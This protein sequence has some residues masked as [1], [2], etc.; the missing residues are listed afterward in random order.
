MTLSGNLGFVPLDEVLRLLTRS[1]NVGVVEITNGDRS[2]RIFVAE[3]GV[4]MATTFDDHELRARLV[5]SGYL[6]ADASEQSVPFNENL[7]SLVREMTVESI[8]QMNTEESDFQVVRDVSS[9][10]SAPQPFDL[11][12]VLEDSVKR[13]AEWEKVSQL[14]PDLTAQMKINREL[15]AETVE[16]NRESWRLL[17]EIG[18]GSSVRDLATS[19]GTTEFAVARVA[20]SMV[21]SDLLVIEGGYRE[22]GQHDYSEPHDYVD[23]EQVDEEPEASYADEQHAYEQNA[24]DHHDD[25]MGAEEPSGEVDP[26]RSWWDEPE[27][28]SPAASVEEDSQ[29]PAAA[30]AEKAEDESGEQDTDAFLEKV[31]S[32]VG[33]ETP[34][35]DGHGLMRRRRMGSILRE[36]GED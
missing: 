2:G 25:E 17:S 11:E 35:E 9:P 22:V 28:E 27:D 26:D 3:A 4:G 34:E 13:A 19:L 23:H 32:E 14:I 31:F 5:S 15:S 33:T 24:E 36:L 12:S 18:R 16:L 6:G 29:E 7:L 21:G 20:A 10:Y 8:Y 30:D 1:G